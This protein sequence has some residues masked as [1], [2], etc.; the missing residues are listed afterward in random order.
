V[1]LRDFVDIVELRTKAVSVTSFGLGTL[2]AVHAGARFS[3]PLAALTLAAVLCVD[4]GTTAFNSYF[5]WERRVDDA[6]FNREHDKVI[7]HGNVAPGWAIVAGLALYALATPIGLAIAALRGV[8]VLAVGAAGM[9]VGFFYNG[10]ARPISHS[11]F[12]ELASG[13]CLG[14]ALFLL[15]YYLQARRLAPDAW[16]ASVPLFLLVGSILTVNN[17]CDVEGDRAAGRRTLSILLG[18]RAAEALVYALG[19]LAYLAAGAWVARGGLP[20]WAAVP[21]AAAFAW[22]LAAYRGMHRRG[23]SHA[24]KGPLMGAVLRVLEAYGVACGGSLLAAILLR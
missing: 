18:P 20:P 23:F 1:S 24:T 2:T 4:M 19:S 3:W 12:G 9:A 16:L 11:P 8:G 10:G 15:C 21:L 22:T 7:I 13:G 6:R 17:T 5:D 14:G